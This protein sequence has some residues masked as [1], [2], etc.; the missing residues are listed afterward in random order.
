[1]SDNH[2]PLLIEPENLAPYLADC[3]ARIVD[4]CS[5]QSYM[6]GHIPGAIHLPA[7][8]LTLSQPPVPGLLP[9]KEQLQRIFSYLGLSPD[10]H[11]FVYD[12]EGGGWAGRFIWTLDVIGHRNYSYINGGIL[13]WRGAGLPIE[14]EENTAE[15]THPDI[16]INPN[17]IMDVQEILDKLDTENFT[18]WDARSPEEYRG[19]KVLAARGGHIPGAINCEW[20]S[21]MD[22]DKG[23]RIR[24][25]AEERLGM[26]GIRKGQEIMT[27]CQT[28]HR[29][30][31]TY[32]LGKILDF[33]IRGYPGSW[34]E[35]GNL[36][37]TPVEASSL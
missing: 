2:I 22:P 9:E 25:D 16:S 11:F 37:G 28:H 10:T 17:P 19:D 14:L 23:F 20:I 6:S 8:T 36:A 34:S 15:T 30:G 13:A 18:I 32:M 3:D 26:L 7:Q 24:E 33:N 12:D 4:L 31:F 35:W 21:L 27:H 1:M 5:E 29:S